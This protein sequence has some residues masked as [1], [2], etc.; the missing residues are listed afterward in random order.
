MSQSN[1]P[2]HLPPKSSSLRQRRAIETLPWLLVF[3]ALTILIATT[4][5]TSFLAWYVPDFVSYQVPAQIN[6]RPA[7]IGGDSIDPLLARNIEERSIALYTLSA[8][9]PTSLPSSQFVGHAVILSSDGLIA[10]ESPV[11]QGTLQALDADGVLHKLQ[12][13]QIDEV[14][15]ITYATLIKGNFLVT[16]IDAWDTV[17]VG[18]N[19]WVRTKDGWQRTT[20]NEIIIA[21]NETQFDLRTPLYS[22][23]TLADHTGPLFGE[24]GIFIGFV[25]DGD[26]TPSWYVRRA[27]P[28]FLT[29][30]A[31]TNSQTTY[32]GA[33]LQAYQDPISGVFIDAPAVQLQRIVPLDATNTSTLQVGDII[34]RIENQSID[35]TD[36]ARQLQLAT[37]AFDMTVLRRGSYVS[38]VFT[39]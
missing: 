27:L 24:A 6:D 15:G 2:P 1:T 22:Y 37:T 36:V 3:L 11:A 29:G 17:S 26:I 20:I 4:V 30:S 10:F 31:V 8:V 18:T 39:P 7:A 38:V 32:T 21:Q 34:T 35:V 16:G 13:D 23:R 5:S 12:I 33:L 25:Q 9:D 14:T 19:G 28:S